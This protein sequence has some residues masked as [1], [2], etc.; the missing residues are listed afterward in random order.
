[1]NP[2]QA[3]AIQKYLTGIAHE[4]YGSSAQASWGSKNQRNPADLDIGVSN[5]RKSA[6]YL[7]TIMERFRDGNQYRLRFKPEFGSA[8]IEMFDT[9]SNMWDTLI[10]IQPL[11]DHQSQKPDTFKLKGKGT[12]PDPY[13]D[14][15]S[16][17]TIQS[18]NNQYLRKLNAVSNPD[19]ADKRKLKDS[20]DMVNLHADFRESEK[21]KRDARILRWDWSELHEIS[22]KEKRYHDPT[23]LTALELGEQLERIHDLPDSTFGNPYDRPLTKKE[24]KKWVWTAVNNPNVPLKDID[25]DKKGSVRIKNKQK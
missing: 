8:A 24:R 17:L 13:S 12:Y 25:I 19:L 9:K 10:D 22:K 2:S 5:V 11:K 23:N 16:G 15:R 18:P 14:K 20:V 3:D 21:L 6:Y 4:I 1:M 7:L